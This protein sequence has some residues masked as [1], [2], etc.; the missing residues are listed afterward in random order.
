VRTGNEIKN[1]S[2]PER[3]VDFHAAY[4]GGACAFTRVG[5]FIGPTLSSPRRITH[6]VARQFVVLE[7]FGTEG[8]LYRNNTQNRHWAAGSGRKVAGRKVDGAFRGPGH[9]AW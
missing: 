8:A 3:A 7:T 4:A 9:R 2:E 1:A 6:R 5:N